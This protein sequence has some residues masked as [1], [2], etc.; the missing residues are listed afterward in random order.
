MSSNQIFAFSE[1]QCT[2]HHIHKH[3]D[4]C[5]EN[6]RSSVAYL[7]CKDQDTNIVIDKL[8]TVFI[9]ETGTYNNKKTLILLEPEKMEGGIGEYYLYKGHPFFRL[10][11]EKKY[12]VRYKNEIVLIITPQP[13][14]EIEMISV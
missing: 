11:S 9:S 12:E 14:W 5:I 8:I 6:V 3:L 10:S 2:I 7:Y 1:K 13:Y 4:L